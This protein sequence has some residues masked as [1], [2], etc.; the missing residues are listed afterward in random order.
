V[1]FIE[2]GERIRLGEGEWLAVELSGHAFGQ[3]GFY[4]ETTKQFIVGDHVLPQITPNVA[5][6][7][8][9]DTDPL[10]TFITALQHIQTYEVS[11]AYPGHRD[12]FEGLRERAEHIIEHHEERLQKMITI[13]RE[14]GAMTA[15]EVCIVTFGDKLGV[16]QMRFALSETIA[17]L[18]H[19]VNRGLLVEQQVD[20]VRK[21]SKL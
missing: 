6:L 20:S 15:Y 3:L 21:F 12:P 1:Q 5:Y 17:H 9:V 2:P 7:P 16:H 10:A 4:E 14:Q 13:L 19:L 18:Y 11:M 8:D